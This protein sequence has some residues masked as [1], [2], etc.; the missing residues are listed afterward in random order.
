MD[1]KEADGGLC[2][3]ASMEGYLDAYNPKISVTP[4][5]IFVSRVEEEIEFK[6]VPTSHME[7]VL[8]FLNDVREDLRCSMAKDTVTIKNESLDMG[9]SAES[10]ERQSTAPDEITKDA[11]M[12]FQKKIT[13]AKHEKQD[14]N[15][16]SL[17][18]KGEVYKQL[19]EMEKEDN[20]VDQLL[21][22]RSMAMEWI[23]GNR[24]H[25]ILVASLID[26]IPNLAGLARTCEM[27]PLASVSEELAEIDGQIADIFRALSNGFQKLEKVK[28]VSR[29]SRQLEEL[30]DKMRDCKRYF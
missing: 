12:D 10:I 1:D 8:N 26:R 11:H 9:E 14:M 16:S 6:C 17:L 23:R 22:S 30:T 15:S 25:I 7:K 24:Q 28:D 27:D 20:L 18:S 3:R 21:K 29:Q 4:A 2:L 19:V 5:G 13:F